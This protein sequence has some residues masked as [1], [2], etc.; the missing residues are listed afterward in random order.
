MSSNAIERIT[1]KGSTNDEETGV[2]TSKAFVLA[3]ASLQCLVALSLLKL[4]F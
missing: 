3:Q 2:D 1:E 4:M